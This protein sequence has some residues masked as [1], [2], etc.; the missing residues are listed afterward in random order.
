[1]WAG[2]IYASGILLT[3]AFLSALQ[4]SK[5]DIDLKDLY[6]RLN[7]VLGEIGRPHIQ[8]DEDNDEGKHGL[9]DFENHYEIQYKDKCK[10]HNWW[11]GISNSGPERFLAI[12]SSTDDKQQQDGAYILWL[13]NITEQIVCA[14]FSET[15]V[16]DLKDDSPATKKVMDIIS[17]QAE[18]E[19]LNAA[20]DVVC[21]RGEDNQNT[22][23][24][25]D[26][27]PHTLDYAW[28]KH[29]KFQTEKAKDS[30]AEDSQGFDM[31]DFEKKREAVYKYVDGILNSNNERHT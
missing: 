20:S 28:D 14:V 21:D 10:L 3:N 29:I 15:H 8:W 19:K 11:K 4:T 31:G 13:R 23:I 27:E 6:N 30:N 17:M 22:S 9:E 25:V 16:Y 2:I 1:M 26:G 7:M 5:D 18:S 12:V 24:T